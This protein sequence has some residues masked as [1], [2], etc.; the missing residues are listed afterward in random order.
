MMILELKLSIRIMIPHL[1]NYSGEQVQPSETNL[2]GG[3]K[4]EK[5]ET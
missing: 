4:T 5:L 1:S 3:G 2:L